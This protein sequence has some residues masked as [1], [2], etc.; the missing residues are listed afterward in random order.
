MP[1]QDH[2][3]SRHKTLIRSDISLLSDDD[4]FLFNEGSHF[5]LYD[6]LGAHPMKVD[7]QDGFYFAVWAP[8]ARAV[9]VMGSFNHWNKEQHPLA[10]RQRS[11]IWEGFIPGIR[12]GTTYKYH[13]RSNQENYEVDK[14]DPFAFYTELSPQTASVTWDLAHEWQDAAWMESRGSIDVKSAP[15]SIYE[16]HLGSWM[17]IPEEKN[18]FPTYRELAQKLPDY[19]VKMGFT[20]VEFLPV[21][22]HPFYGSWGYQCLGYFAPSS[23]FGTPQDFMYLVEQLHQKNIGVIL[24]W[25]PSHFP[26]DEHG[27]GYFDGTHLFEHEDPRKGFH[28]DWKSLIFNYGRN[29]VICYLISSA[30][31]WL[32]NYHID[33]FRVD[34]VASMLYLDY[35][36][37][38]DEWVPNIFGGR[39]NLEAVDFLKRFNEVLHG[40]FPGTITIAEESTDWPMVSRPVHLGGLGFDMK[41]DMGWMH[42]TLAYMSIDPIHRSF[43]HDTLTFRMIYA[44]KENYV[45]PLSHDEVVHGKRSLLGKMPGDDWQKFANLRLLFGYM[46]AQPAKKLIFMGGEIGQIREWNHDSSLDWHLL[47][48]SRNKGLQRWIEDLNQ[49]YRRTPAM[50]SGDFSPQGFQWIDCHDVQQSTLSFLRSGGS[51]SGGLSADQIIAVCN[52]TPIPR[53]NYRIG[54]FS[55][56]VWKEC[57]NSDAKEYGGSNLGSLGQIEAS[58]VPCHGFSFSLNLVLPPLGIV[59]LQRMQLEQDAPAYFHPARTNR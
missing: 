11:G 4:V 34:A 3:P 30:R 48:N 53:P 10:S 54:V 20:H 21:M 39:E 49:F 25:V 57:L 33:G 13:I 26:S 44:F 41:W 24:D 52:F 45:L 9:S 56:G 36:R 18:R 12:S 29:E 59:F 46:Y 28:P 51:S 17:R 35:S 43:H 15:M 32:E 8:N 7:G 27:L 47:E 58:P 37:K 50:H 16:M 2:S 22:E 42:D 1:T 5:C 6:K 23:R 38:P 40:N 14:T 55:D 31:F 19:L